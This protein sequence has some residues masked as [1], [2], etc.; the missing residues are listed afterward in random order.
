MALGNAGPMN[1]EVNVLMRPS[2]SP[3]IS[4]GRTADAAKRHHHESVDGPDAHR[5]RERHDD[6]EDGAGRA[7]EAA[8][9]PKVRP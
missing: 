5:R 1:C 3:P 6:A 2:S 8:E 4:A 7:G 9:T